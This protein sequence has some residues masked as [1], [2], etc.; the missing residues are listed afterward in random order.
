MEKEETTTQSYYI[1]GVTARTYL[2]SLFEKSKSFFSILSPTIRRETSISWT[3]PDLLW[4]MDERRLS[5]NWGCKKLIYFQ[6]LLTSFQDS[7]K[8]YVV[9]HFQ[10]NE[11]IEYASE[12][13]MRR[14]HVNKVYAFFNI[15]NGFKMWKSC[16]WAY[17]YFRHKLPHVYD[18]TNHLL[19]NSTLFFQRAGFPIIGKYSLVDGLYDEV[20]FPGAAYKGNNV[21]K[22]SSFKSTE[23]TIIISVPL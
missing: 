19:F 8:R 1:Q 20:P 9:N 12:A 11:V 23:K 22:N 21:R 17:N 10:G 7:L 5:E 15:P 4:R 6:L 3:F 18:G 16:L 13:E 14:G 2:W